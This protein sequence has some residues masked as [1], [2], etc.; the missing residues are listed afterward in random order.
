MQRNRVGL[1]FLLLLI[2]GCALCGASGLA[3]TPFAITAANLAMPADDP[4]TTS[5]G[6]T[7]IHMGSSQFTV[8]GVGE[9]TLTIGCQY[10]GPVTQA[11]IPQQCGIVWPGRVTVQSGETTVNGTVYFVPYGQGPVP[12]L[13]QLHTV[14]RP[15]GRLPATGMALA[16]ALMLGLGFR[17][18]TSRVLLLAILVAC[19]LIG[20]AGI[21]GCTAGSSNTMT[22]GTYSYTISA[23]FAKTG[24]NAIQTA[25]TTVTLTVQ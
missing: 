14:P 25:T 7:A 16:G 1:F 2:A 10:S 17:R 24:S 3:A 5:D 18:Q 11:K 22:P 23:D 13:A 6:G 9:G 20:A 21:T 15:S 19:T 4:P 12:S 8:A